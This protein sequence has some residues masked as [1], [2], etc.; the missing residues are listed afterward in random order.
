VTE[1][2]W[3]RRIEWLALSFGW[4]VVLN[5]G[6]LLLPQLWCPPSPRICIQRLSVVR[7]ESVVHTHLHVV[8]SSLATYW[9]EAISEKWQDNAWLCSL[10]KENISFFI[11]RYELW[12]GSNW[13][14][15]LCRVPVR[16]ISMVKEISRAHSGHSDS[17]GE[18][19]NHSLCSFIW[20]FVLWYL[21]FHFTRL[22]FP[23]FPVERRGEISA[24]LISYWSMGIFTWLA[25]NAE[26]K[27]A[28]YFSIF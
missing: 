12:H 13:E 21:S 28:M 15:L 10:Q 18:K 24:F 3:H 17:V 4:S 20:F 19:A 8:Q 14:Y 27:I 2:L 9:S 23:Q 7:L 11:P 22:L 16:S 1:D 25:N 5:T 26:D 6:K